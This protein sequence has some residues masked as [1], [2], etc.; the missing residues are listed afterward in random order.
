MH[1]IIIFVAGAI[2]GVVLLGIAT[3]GTK[4][5]RERDAYNAGYEAGLA[6]KNQKSQNT[7]DK[8]NT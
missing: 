8:T 6:Q 3:V 1:E 2:V 4:K 5:E 7:Q